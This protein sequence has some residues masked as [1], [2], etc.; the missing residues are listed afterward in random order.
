M[1]VPKHTDTIGASKHTDNFGA[2]N[3]K[4]GFGVSKHRQMLL[5]DPGKKICL[6]CLG[7]LVEATMQE[8]T[9]DLWQGEC[10]AKHML[11]LG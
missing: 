4:D 11:L 7:M 9:R 1:L 2:S 6:D 8:E 10:G 5:S 3:P